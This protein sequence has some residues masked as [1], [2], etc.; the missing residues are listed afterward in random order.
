MKL[1]LPILFLVNPIF[2]W[3]NPAL[4]LKVILDGMKNF[5]ANFEQSVFDESGQLLE[6]TEGLVTFKMPNYFKWLY[7]K[8]H[9]NQ[10]ISD[11]QEIYIYDPDLAQVIISKINLN[12][13]NNPA[14]IFMEK[15][16]ESSFNVNLITVDDDIWYRCTPKS[17]KTGYE[18]IDLL[19][20]D[21]RT[22]K[23]MLVTDFLKNKIII[24]FDF[25]ENNLKIDD[26]FFM[27]NFPENV[28]VIKN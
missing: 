8:P 21:N 28:E 27:F 6:E 3:A 26:A 7:K 24:N 5:K 14:V 20:N 1:F 11:G 18:N 16:I 12:D 25:I 9:K 17:D 15:N 22:L 4:E 13:G 19:F 10:I 2:L 23:S